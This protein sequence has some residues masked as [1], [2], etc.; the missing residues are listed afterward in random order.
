[1]R[2]R[3]T[4]QISQLL[5]DGSFSKTGFRVD[6]EC[7]EDSEAED[8]TSTLDSS[9]EDGTSAKAPALGAKR[10]DHLVVSFVC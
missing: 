7:C 8:T 1:M 4:V 2:C 3:I 6:V 9:H 5:E 10:E